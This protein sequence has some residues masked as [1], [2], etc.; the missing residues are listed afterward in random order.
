MLGKRSS[1]RSLF[2]AEY[3]FKSL[4]GEDSFHWQL[5]QVRDELFSDE[6]FAELYCLNN[7]R[8]S[9]PPSLLATALLL[10]AH[11]KVSDAE[12]QRR[13]RLDLGW[14]VA[15]GVDADA[16]PFAQSTLQHFRAQLI[17]HDKLRDLFV[18][19]LELAREKGLLKSKALRLVLDTTPILGR[20]AVKDTYNLLAD[21]IRQLLRTMA[22]VE[23]AEEDSWAEREGYGRYLEASIKGTAAVDWNDREAM[24]A[25]LAGIVADAKR[26]LSQALTSAPFTDAEDPAHAQIGEAAGLLCKLLLQDIEVGTNGPA[27]R[28]GVSKDRIVSVADPEMRHGRKSSQRRFDGHKASVAVDAE[29]QL[30]T[31]VAVL[32]G[33]GPDA[34][35]ALDLVCESEDNTEG[36][37]TE[38]VADTAYGDGETRQ[39]F[40]EAKRT[41]IATVPKPAD[42]G[43]F[44]KQDFQIDLEAGQ[45]TCPAGQVSRHLRR[46]STVGRPDGTRAVRQAFV[47]EAA[48]CDRCPLRPQCVK[49]KPGRGRT[50]SLHPQEAL[51]HKARTFQASAAFKP[52]RAIRQV[53]EHRLARLMQLGLRQARYLGRH[54]TEAQ[55]YL[56]ATVANLTR[57]WAAKPASQPTLTSGEGI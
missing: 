14:K 1:Q 57:T 40:A 22:K 34:K 42:N 25:F 56:A 30:I 29:S 49:A 28:Q 31:A 27:L 21:G 55:L 39:Q 9:V 43:Y 37:V 11:D 12:A 19:S 44:P 46:Q 4:I 32:P 3:H 35:G 8:P 50:V 13:A 7:G 16:K 17:L 18:R 23:G 41:L 24:R 48:I 5:S 26:L 45:C 33:N 51:L 15:L 6:A 10:Q 47:F 52:Y 2:D 54:K 20:G 38:T 36:E 53:A